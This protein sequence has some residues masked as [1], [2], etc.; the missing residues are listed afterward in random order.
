VE[1]KVSWVPGALPIP[2]LA[3]YEKALGPGHTSTLRTVNELGDIYSDQAKLDEAE[4]M[5]ERAR[6]N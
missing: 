6:R 2:R 4:E 5:F 3:E 1:E